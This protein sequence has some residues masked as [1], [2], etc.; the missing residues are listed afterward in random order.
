MD[1]IYTFGAYRNTSH[2]WV[3]QLRN[4]HFISTETNIDVCRCIR[5]QRLQSWR[6]HNERQ[7]AAVLQ[8]RNTLE[9]RYNK[10]YHCNLL[11][12]LFFCCALCFSLSVSKRKKY[13]EFFAF[14]L[15]PR[16]I[17][18]SDEFPCRFFAFFLVFCVASNSRTF[19]VIIYTAAIGVCSSLDVHV[20]CNNKCWS[21]SLTHLLYSQN[22]T[23]PIR[24]HEE[25]N[26]ITRRLI[27]SRILANYSVYVFTATAFFIFL[28]SESI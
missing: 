24:S 12:A 1:L 5:H 8:Q 16:H 7:F 2:E 18:E 15:L 28:Y 25:G 13:H 22:K 21:H 9:S 10:R 14:V 4:H 6:P 3:V 20:S 27:P 26:N 11:H 17:H 19:T 23:K